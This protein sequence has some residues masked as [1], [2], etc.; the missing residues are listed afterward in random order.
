MKV[1]IPVLDNYCFIVA[2]RAVVLTADCISLSL[3]NE[4]LSTG[5]WLK[6]S[7]QNADEEGEEA[8]SQVSRSVS[9]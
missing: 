1:P 5:F 6:G 9:G 7:L 4:L 8:V 2:I 3:D